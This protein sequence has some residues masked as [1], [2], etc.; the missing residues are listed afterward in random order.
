M[1]HRN[2]GGRKQTIRW[3]RLGILVEME[4]LMS[5]SFLGYVHI[6]PISITFAYIP[7]LLTGVLMGPPESTI[8]GTAFGLASMWKAS[9]SY[10]MPADKLFS[11]LLSG[12]PVESLLLSVGTRVLFGLLVGFLYLAAKR[13]RHK[14]LWIGVIS[15]SGVPFTPC[16]STAPCGAFSRRRATRP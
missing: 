6:A 13:T 2:R 12:H 4:L 14:G 9:A 7:V 8:L 10:V 15:F 11:P 16:W 1:D 3:Y 5:F